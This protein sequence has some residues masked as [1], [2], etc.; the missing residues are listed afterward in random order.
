M[1]FQITINF[2]ETVFLFAAAY[3][4][5]ARWA[6]PP[7]SSS[8]QKFLE[9][10]IAAAL[11]ATARPLDMPPGLLWFVYGIQLFVSLHFLVAVLASLAAQVFKRKEIATTIF[12]N[13]DRLRR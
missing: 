9:W 6:L 8:F 13:E 10:S 12:E 11:C 5:V 7:S 2:A 1:F 4:V 3:T